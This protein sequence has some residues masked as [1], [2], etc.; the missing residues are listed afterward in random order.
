MDNLSNRDKI[1]FTE[2]FKDFTEF[3]A[4]QKDYVMIQKREYNPE[5][6]LFANLALD[7]VDFKDR[8][9][10]LARDMALLDVTRPLQKNN[11]DELLKERQQLQT[12]LKEVEAQLEKD[13]IEEGYSSRELE[14]PDSKRNKRQ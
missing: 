4:D 11:V 9:R 13:A 2:I 6:S 1:R 5:L 7:L 12:V 14:G 3:R 10:P 8:V